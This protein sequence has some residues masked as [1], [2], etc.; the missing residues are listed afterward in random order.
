MVPISAVI[1][2]VLISFLHDT[3]TALWIGGM[4]ALAFSVLPAIRKILGKSKE[5]KALNALIKK[6][7]SLLTYISMIG[8]II[9]GLLMSRKAELAGLYTGFLSFGTEYSTLLSIKH[10]LYFVMISLSVFRSLIVDRVKKF[11]PE[12]KKMLNMLTLM[13][14]VLAGL[15]VLFLSAYTNVLASL[16][17]P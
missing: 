15:A 12:Q 11:S 7:L 9:T 10:L 6:K 13:L 5:T 3:F 2:P 4:L 16:P 14:N 17:T 1:A 8:L